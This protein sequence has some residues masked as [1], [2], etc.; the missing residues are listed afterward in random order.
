MVSLILYVMFQAPKKDE[1][2][3]DKKTFSKL[4]P[5]YT[6]SWKDELQSLV[7][8]FRTSGITGRDLDTFL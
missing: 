5:L 4:Q 1:G 7:A 3:R 6:D 2:G 8:E